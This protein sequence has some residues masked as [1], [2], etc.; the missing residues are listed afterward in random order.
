MFPALIA[1]ISGLAGGLLNKPKTTQQ[2]TNSTTNTSSEQNSNFN[3]STNP[4]YDP[5]QLQMRNFLISQYQNRLNPTG[6]Q[7]TVN[8]YIGQGVNNINTSANTNQQAL[9]N[10]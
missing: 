2:N 4:V 6:I 10:V 8:D 1:G 3:Q 7:N 5:L 9:S